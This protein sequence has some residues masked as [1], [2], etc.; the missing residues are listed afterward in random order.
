MRRHADHRERA[1]GD[2][3]QHQRRHLREVAQ[4]VALGE[5]RLLQ[6]LAGGPVDAIEVRQADAM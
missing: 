2:V 5:R 4:Q 6:G 3:R 1:V